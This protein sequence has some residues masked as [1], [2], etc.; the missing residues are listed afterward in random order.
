MRVL[1]VVQTLKGGGAESL[2]CDLLP[3]L[4]LRGIDAGVIAVYSAD[5]T[6]AER[7]ALDC[8][9]VEIHKKRGLD[10][11]APYRLW[12]AIRQWR[13]DIVH[14]H[15]VTGKYWGRACAALAGVPTIVHTEHS[16]L[17]RLRTWEWPASYILNLRTKAMITFSKRTAQFLERRERAKKLYIIPNGIPVGEPPSE[18][19]RASS[20]I[21]LGADGRIVIG[22]VANLYPQKNHKLALDAFSR[23]PK[24]VR[25]LARIHMFGAGPLEKAL[26][27]Q[28]SELG[29]N[30]DIVF[31]GFESNVR[32]LFPGMDIFLSVALFEAAPISYLE[33]MNAAL[34]IVGTPS[35]GTLDMVVDGV[36]G[37]VIPTWNPIDVV[38]ALEKAITDPHWRAS[39]GIASW[40]R[41]RDCYN[42]ESA[43]DQHVQLY[44]SLA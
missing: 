27:N 43:A 44:R 38:S 18:T 29:I 3:R 34:P 5:L 11:Q 33:A 40:Q 25:E 20:K 17:P 9:I 28:A 36:T 8:D 32:T 7:Q 13:P 26:K 14:T 23:L 42:I 4:R 21:A 1:H 41:L 6:S 15:V 12:R 35:I 2:V 39:A 22:V 37:I 24:N 19:D 16:P 31:H 30:E 10:L